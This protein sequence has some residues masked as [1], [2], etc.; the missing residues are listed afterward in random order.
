MGGTYRYA[1]G[2]EV[3]ADRSRSQIEQALMRGGATAFA[4]GQTS[5]P[6]TAREEPTGRKR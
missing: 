6:P 5:E 4:Y 2:T 3:S 1:Q